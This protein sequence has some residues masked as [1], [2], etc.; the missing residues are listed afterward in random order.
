MNYER[1]C[2]I[3]EILHKHTIDCVKTAYH[4]MALKHHPDK[5]DPEKFKEIL[6]AK[7]G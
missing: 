1:A 3:L 7:T 5:G 2:N 4:K 6:E